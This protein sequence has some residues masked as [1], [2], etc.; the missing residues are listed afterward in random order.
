MAKLLS[1]TMRVTTMRMEMP[2]QSMRRA[3]EA[4][5]GHAAIFPA[6]ARPARA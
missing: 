2:V 5:I 4:A 1:A 6:A 3:A